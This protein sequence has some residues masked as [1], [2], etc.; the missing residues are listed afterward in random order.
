MLALLR[1]RRVIDDQEGV[2]AAHQ[3]IGF[4]QQSRLERRPVP[5]AGGHEVV[6]LVVAADATRAAIGWM[7]LRSPGPIRPATYSGHIRP[8]RLVP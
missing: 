6:Q 4:L 3:P 2:S 1:Q 7:L 5:G 8:R